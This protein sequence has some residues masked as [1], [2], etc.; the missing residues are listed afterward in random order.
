MAEASCQA[1]KRL[2]S[3][4]SPVKVGMKEDASA[5]PATRAKIVSE[6]R[7]AAVK[8]SISGSV[9]NAPATR[10]CRA[11]PI[12]LLR[13]KAAITVPAA[14]ATRW[15]EVPASLVMGWIITRDMRKARQRA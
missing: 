13:M 5:P 7:F 12:R 2:S 15:L 8:A 3:V 10:I 4:S 9:P 11:S 14:R 1:C 6:T